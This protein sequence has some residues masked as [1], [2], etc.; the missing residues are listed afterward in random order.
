VSG[1][2]EFSDGSE[3]TFPLTKTELPQ[4]IEFAPRTASWVILKQL[5]K[6]D[7]ESPFPALSQIEIWGTE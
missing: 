2:L 3:I 7:D 6:A 4:T 5:I 1:T